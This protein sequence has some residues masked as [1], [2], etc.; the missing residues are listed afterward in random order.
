MLELLT[1]PPP[2]EAIARMTS[3]EGVRTVP[4][5]LTTTRARPTSRTRGGG[6]GAYPAGDFCR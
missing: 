3:I 6:C 1:E 2:A 4:T 5:L